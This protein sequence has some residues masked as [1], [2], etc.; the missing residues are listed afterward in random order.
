MNTKEVAL[1]EDFS[2]ADSLNRIKGYWD[3]LTPTD[4]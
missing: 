2:V 1:V 3:K 4:P